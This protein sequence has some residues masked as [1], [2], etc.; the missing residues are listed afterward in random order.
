MKCSYTFVSLQTH[1][2]LSNQFWILIN[3]PAGKN[4]KIVEK[5]FENF[6]QT[7][8]LFCIEVEK[9]TT[10]KTFMT[11]REKSPPREI[12]CLFRYNAV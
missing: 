2:E 7:F 8:F 4:H 10:P 12:T 6:F 9:H 11:H 3:V 5:S 1:F